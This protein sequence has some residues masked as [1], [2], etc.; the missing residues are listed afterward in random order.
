M[1]TKIELS[2]SDFK[3]I[4]DFISK[5][6]GINIGHKK[7]LVESRL[8]SLIGKEFQSFS[9]LVDH[10]YKYRDSIT[11]EIINRITTNFTYFFRDMVHFKFLR[12]YLKENAKKEIRIW[13]AAC[14]SGEEPYSIAITALESIKPSTFDFFK[15]LATDISTKVLVRAYSG[16]YEG[17]KIRSHVPNHLIPKYFD[18]NKE[19]DLYLVKKYLKDYISFRRFNLK[20]HVYPFK[21]K[22]DIVFLRNVMIYFGK[23]EKELILQN[24]YDHMK[25]GSFLILGLG[26]SLVGIEHPFKILKYSIYKK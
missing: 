9:E 24:I 19:N 14:S 17:D 1:L 13:S 7:Y 16:V 3:R 22:F 20:E 5:N 21:H 15:I 10:L 26:E 23:E 18:Y 11:Q 6:L 25:E 12:W 4:S 2:D 8:A